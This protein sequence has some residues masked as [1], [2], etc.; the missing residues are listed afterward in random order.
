MDYV[1]SLVTT[2]SAINNYLDNEASCRTEHDG[3]ICNMTFSDMPVVVGG[4]LLT[5]VDIFFGDYVHSYF[6]FD[7]ITND[8]TFEEY[9]IPYTDSATGDPVR[10][11]NLVVI[12]TDVWVCDGV[13]MDM[14]LTGEGDGYFMVNGAMAPIKWTRETEDS[15]FVFTYEDGSPVIFG[16]GTTFI[17]VVNEYGGV[18]A[19]EE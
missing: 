4:S 13:H 11:K 7:P 3:Y 17:A 12:R 1:H 16:V 10:F 9:D 19:F 14:T 5:N 15:Q 6:T 18:S 2:G 8:Y